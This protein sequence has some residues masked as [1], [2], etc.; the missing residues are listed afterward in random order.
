MQRRL[1]MKEK[2]V[3]R[4]VCGKRLIIRLGEDLWNKEEWAM[5]FLAS[6]LIRANLLD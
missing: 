1:N 4:E 3:E 5:G 6:R 2:L